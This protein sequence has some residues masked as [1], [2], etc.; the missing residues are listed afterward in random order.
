MEELPQPL[1]QNACT[2]VSMR[3]ALAAMHLPDLIAEIV[4]RSSSVKN[5]VL[6]LLWRRIVCPLGLIKDFSGD[7][8]KVFD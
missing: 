3:S 1:N 4:S 5:K 2:A 6:R 8:L 7:L